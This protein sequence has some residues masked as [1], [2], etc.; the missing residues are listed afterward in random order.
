MKPMI[1]LAMLFVASGAGAQ[2]MNV[3]AP[4]RVARIAQKSV[5]FTI[6]EFGYSRQQ[7]LSLGD[8]NQERTK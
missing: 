7:E 6:E 4:K 3:T 1:L 5:T 8:S 2:S